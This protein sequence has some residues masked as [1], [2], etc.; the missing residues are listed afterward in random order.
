MHPCRRLFFLLNRTTSI[1]DTFMWLGKA[2]TSF[3][4][5]PRQIK[6]KSNRLRKKIW[7]LLNDSLQ[8]ESKIHSLS[9]NSLTLNETQLLSLGL[10]YI[11]PSSLPSTNTILK[12]FS[13]LSRS[14]RLKHFFRDMDSTP[15]NPFKLPN[16]NWNPPSQYIPLLKI[17]LKNMKISFCLYSNNLNPNLLGHHST[18]AQPLSALGITTRLSFFRWI[19]TWEYVF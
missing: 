12:E 18:F 13:S 8:I 1:P 2:N 17:L 19:R 11:P 16:P 4:F 10:K 9:K 15:L 3:P 7:K 14:L 5:R 6:S